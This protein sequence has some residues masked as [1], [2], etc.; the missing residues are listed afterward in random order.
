MSS[1]PTEQVAHADGAGSGLSPGAVLDHGRYRLLGQVGFD[2]RCNAQLWRAKDGVLGR[3]VALTILLG[4][5]SDA[6][7]AAAARRT[8][9]R[10][11]HASTFNHVGVARV[12]DVV[13]QA[14][15]DPAGVLGTVI[16]EW[17]HGVDLT[18]LVGDGPL[19]PG[20]AARLLQPLAGAVEA[21]HHAGLVLGTDHPQRIRVTA[22]GEVRLAFPGPQASAN[23]SSDVQ[24]LGAAL[25]LLL[26]GHW[27]VPGGPEGLPPAPTGPDG[28]VV[29]PRT[30]RSVIP[31]E[32]ST[33]AVRALGTPEATGTTGGVRTGAAVL[34]VLEQYAS[35]DSTASSSAAHEQDSGENEVWRTDDE[36]PDQEKRKKLAISVAVLAVATLLVVGWLAAGIVGIFTG[37]GTNA[38][39]S[40][41]V[42]QNNGNG[43]AARPPQSP[44]APLQIVD[45]AAYNP[46]QQPDSPTKVR[47]LFNG[48]PSGWATSSYFQQFG[49][50]Y[51]RGSGV[52]LALAQ[53]A[54]VSQVVIDTA[55]PGTR[56]EIRSADSP[57]PNLDASPVIGAKDLTAGPNPIPVNAA[58]PTKYVL[59]W[60]TQL[61][62]GP[63]GQFQSRLNKVTIYG[64][65]R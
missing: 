20:T 57:N 15:G 26:T 34:R 39:P 18:E 43:Q 33:V 35:L 28:T 8:L 32:L 51:T 59:V 16:A 10:A 48:D 2:S 37:P 22:E 64:T 36:K 27:A 11:M 62:P 46:D 12:L 53:P 65:S 41:I 63:G 25:Y 19:A 50:G 21:A 14:P 13:S 6:E 40:M 17:T 60:I 3:D 52:V 24:G 5:R 38:G 4:D 9:E 31:L 49:T 7:D 45:G 44:S 23:S 42:G 29:A 55:S 1:K 61:A 54:T 47:N 56:V 30:L 58:Q